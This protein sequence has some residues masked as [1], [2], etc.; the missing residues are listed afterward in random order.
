MKTVSA[1]PSHLA[2]ALSALV[3]TVL[4]STSFLLVKLSLPFVPPI[5]LAAVRYLV[6]FLFLLAYALLIDRRRPTRLAWMTLVV[7]GVFNFGV[8]QGL[9]YSAMRELPVA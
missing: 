6:A 8:S 7:I 2:A 1:R 5:T 9:Q 3:V 4:W